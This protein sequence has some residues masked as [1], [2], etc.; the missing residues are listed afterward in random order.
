[1]LITIYKIYLWSKFLTSK[2][3][4][5]V[6]IF[7]VLGEHLF[8]GC[9]NHIFYISNDNDERVKNLELI[10][11]LKLTLSAFEVAVGLP[12]LTEERRRHNRSSLG[13]PNAFGFEYSSLLHLIRVCLAS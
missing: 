6:A 11:T 10:T 1:M 12:V 5:L 7:R 4:I 3:I 13:L 9:T 8:F 2:D